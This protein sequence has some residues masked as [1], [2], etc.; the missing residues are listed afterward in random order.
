MHPKY[1][2]IRLK[3]IIIEEQNMESNAGVETKDLDQ[4][5]GQRYEKGEVN[6]DKPGAG[7]QL[8]LEG[9]DV[10]TGFKPDYDN[11]NF[12]PIDS[13]FLIEHDRLE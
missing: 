11:Q 5:G 2:E 6:I 7:H 13:E 10:S 9:D 4:L 3:L 1:A 8:Y 12:V